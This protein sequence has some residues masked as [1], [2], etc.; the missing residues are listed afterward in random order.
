MLE[1]GATRP[2]SCPCKAWTFDPQIEDF[3]Q[4]LYRKGSNFRKIK[5]FTPPSNFRR[6]DPP[7]PG[8]QVLGKGVGNN[9]NA[10]RNASE[11]RQ[12]CVKHAPQ[13]VLF[14]QEERNVPKCVKNARNTFG[15]EHLLDDTE[16]CQ[17]R[18]KKTLCVYFSKCV[19]LKA[20]KRL[21]VAEQNY[22]SACKTSRN[23]KPRI[24]IRTLLAIPQGLD[25]KA[26]PHH[27]TIPC[28]KH[29]F[30][31]RGERIW[32]IAIQRVLSEQKFRTESPVFSRERKRPGFRRKRDSREL[33]LP[34]WPKRFPLQLLLFT[35]AIWWS[36]SDDARETE[37]C[38]ETKLPQ[39]GWGG[40]GGVLARAASGTGRIQFR[41]ARF[42]TQSSPV[43]PYP[44][45]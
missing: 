25:S 6:F 9:K 14:Y 24:R 33:L 43:N 17:Q 7:Y 20:K 26:I 30:R 2:E 39:L 35:G 19:W 36:D 16:T 31:Y 34:L 8:L 23:G 10:S 15:G 45:N 5:I 12:K 41:R 1:G 4:K 37:R 42:Q 40:A 3:L 28:S 32:A 29:C 21:A 38:S 18:S 13:W 27:K 22:Y 11:I 44:L